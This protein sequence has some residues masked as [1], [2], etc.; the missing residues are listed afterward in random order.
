MPLGPCSV[1]GCTKQAQSKCNYMCIRCYRASQLPQ[2]VNGGGGGGFDNGGV[3]G[4]GFINGDGNGGGFNHGGGVD[5]GGFDIGGINGGGVDGGGGG[6]NIGGINGGGVEP[7]RRRFW[8]WV[9]L[10]SI[11]SML[12]FF[13]VDNDDIIIPVCD[14]R[15]SFN[16]DNV[17]N[18]C[19]W[20][21][22]PM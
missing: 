8:V 12:G 21:E 19:F 15:V 6:F 4:G 10:G 18:S 22:N 1:F 13:F 3:N 2:D 5:G 14:H 16:N 11:L 17:D 9:V 7:V 20:W